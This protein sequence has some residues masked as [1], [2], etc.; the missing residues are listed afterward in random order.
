M[1]QTASS[2]PSLH[3]ATRVHLEVEP[4]GAGGGM[5]LAGETVGVQTVDLTFAGR[6]ARASRA[7]HSAPKSTPEQTAPTAS[8][9]A[10]W[11]P[12]QPST[13]SQATGRLCRPD[14]LDPPPPSRRR[15]PGGGAD[16]PPPI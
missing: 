2:V 15:G 4:R 14:R 12:S 7:S 16:L 3:P 13:K 10:P 1:D 6:G 5:H 11:K 8:R 9:H